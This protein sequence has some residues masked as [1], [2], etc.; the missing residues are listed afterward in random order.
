MSELI[1][2]I[3]GPRVPRVELVKLRQVDFFPPQPRLKELSRI[4]IGTKTRTIGDALV[5]STLPGKLKARYP[6]LQ[7]DTYPRGFNPVVFYGNPHV[8]GVSYFPG[9]LYGDD[10]NSGSGQLIELKERFFG[11]PVSEKPRPEIH[12]TAHESKGIPSSDLPICVIHPWGKTRS[13]VLNSVFWEDK[14]AALKNKICFWQVGIE[15]QAPIPGCDQVFLLPRGYHNARKLFALM[16]RADFFVGVDSGPMHVAR[17]FG[18]P[19]F[20]F[21][22]FGVRPEELFRVRR[23]NPYYLHSNL[24]SGFLYEENQHVDV[25]LTS[26]PRIT[27]AL[28]LFLARKGAIK[29]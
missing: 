26:P 25:T 23:E 8:S 18:V 29:G 22:D 3:L 28:D 16:R 10:C 15:G 7:I 24:L 2:K 19:S 27:E 12:L 14:I 11:L 4:C 5:L 21:L 6:H 1:W 13:Q 20:V 9:K 17:A